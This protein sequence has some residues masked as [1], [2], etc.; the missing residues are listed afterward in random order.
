M[1]QLLRHPFRV[2]PYFRPRIWGARELAPWY[3]HP[4]AADA[5]P[6]GEVWL[7]GGQC[8][9][10]TGPC[11]GLTLDEATRLHAGDLLGVSHSVAGADAE[12]PLLIKVLFPREKLSV[13]VHPD[14]ATA[15]IHGEP[16]GKT[17]C[18]Y[19]LDADPGA[20]LALGLEQGTTVAAV[21]A[22]IDSG[23]LEDLLNWLPVRKGDLFFVDAGTV[24]AIGPGSVL[25]ETQ[26]TSD[27]TYR[28][29]DYGR[30]REL[31][32]QKS[33]EAMR[34]ATQA[35]LV[36]TRMRD[37]AEV[38]IE[39][40]FFT[41]ERLTRFGEGASEA[42][43]GSL[44][45]L[46]CASGAADISCVGSEPLRLLKGQLAVIPAVCEGLTIAAERDAELIRVLPGR[47]LP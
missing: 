22:A 18:W 23:T 4:L 6:I 8:V 32:L 40:E 35:G 24:H 29:Y 47:L 13:Q 39:S 43:R 26:Q 28:L 15:Q 33:F 5:E 9:V 45:M 19:A 41:L 44:Q 38:L 30:P 37:D 46:F 31:H 7:T 1:T 16:R 27:L 36:A 25:L 14:D 21:A 10:E 3:S 17:E 12:F 34:L 20:Q 2:A 11:A 42:R